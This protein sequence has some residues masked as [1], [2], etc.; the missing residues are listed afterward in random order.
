VRIAT[1]SDGPLAMELD[2]KLAEFEALILLNIAP[3]VRLRESVA[4]AAAARHASLHVRAEALQALLDGPQPTPFDSPLGA[5]VTLHAQIDLGGAAPLLVEVGAGVHVEAPAREALVLLRRLAAE[6][7]SEGALA[8][9]SAKAARRDLISA[10][11]SVAALGRLAEG[12][13]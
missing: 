11:E 4:A 2:T 13:E 12:K 6:A 7:L 3:Q 1:S 9:H 5:G 10:C 8:E